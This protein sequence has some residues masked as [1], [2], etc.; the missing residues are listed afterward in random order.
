MQW[1]YK[2]GVTIRVLESHMASALSNDLPSEPFERSD[3]SAQSD[4]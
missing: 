3:Q 2:R 1:H 4:L